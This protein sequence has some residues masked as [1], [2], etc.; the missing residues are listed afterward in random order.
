MT[1]DTATNAAPAFLTGNMLTRHAKKA[2][3]LIVSS[4]DT[5]KHRLYDMDIRSRWSSAE[6]DDLTP[7][8]VN[9]GL[10]LPG[11]QLA[12]SFDYVA[13]MNHNVASM[14]VERSDDNGTSWADVRA[15]GAVPADE[16]HTRVSLAS[17]VDGDRL[18]FTFS[19][20]KTANA[21]KLVGGIIVAKL[22][23]Q[24]S[25]G[26]KIYQRHPP[27]VGHKSAEMSD[28]SR[29]RSY[30]YRT[31]ASF[32]HRSFSLSFVGVSDDEL[33]DFQELF[34]HRPEPII[35]LPEPGRRTGEAYFCQVIPGTYSDNY[36][37]AG[38]PSAGSVVSFDLEEVGGA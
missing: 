13:V 32:T 25:M 14:R 35:F 31:D 8:T 16:I 26:M 34:M 7:E 36:M 19:T 37:Q 30:V 17:P 9:F 21:E 29:R 18:R 24:P 6:S 4:G 23:L 28:R 5:L 20:T 38:N 2:S 27:R 15:A 22:L 1:L 3:D 33:E 11:V 12:Q 10:W